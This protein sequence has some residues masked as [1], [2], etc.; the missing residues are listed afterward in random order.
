MQVPLLFLAE[1]V[2]DGAEGTGKMS[3]SYMMHK[4]DLVAGLFDIEG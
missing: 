4:A 3:F 2:K 1:A